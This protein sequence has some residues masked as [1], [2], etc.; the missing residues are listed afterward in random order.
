[1][2]YAPRVL[3]GTT[4][5]IPNLA[6]P[7]VPSEFFI[8]YL[9]ADNIWAVPTAAIVGI[10]LYANHNGVLPIVQVLLMKGVPVGTT[11]TM[12]M[13]ITAISLPEM[14]MLN[15]VLSWKMLLIFA[16]YLLVAFTFVGYLLNWIM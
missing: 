4:S 6:G 8:K 15:K 7:L 9:G 11:L 12:L 14:I 16:S 5:N 13:S 1:M 3:A 2:D 10:P